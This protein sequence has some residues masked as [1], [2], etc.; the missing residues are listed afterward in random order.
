VGASGDGQPGVIGLGRVA[1][2]F[3]AA[4]VAAWAMPRLTIHATR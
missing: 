4:F 3:V 1:S 2:A